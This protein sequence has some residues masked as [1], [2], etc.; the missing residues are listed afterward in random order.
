RRLARNLSDVLQCR[1]QTKV[2]DFTVKYLGV[3]SV[4]EPCG[5]DY[6]RMHICSGEI[7]RD[8]FDRFQ[9]RLE[10]QEHLGSIGPVAIPSLFVGQDVVQ[11]GTGS[12]RCA[13]RAPTLD[14]DRGTVE[15]DDVSELCDLVEEVEVLARKATGKAAN[16]RIGGRPKR[17]GAAQ[18]VERIGRASI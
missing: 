3:D 13:V 6:V 9:P 14:E 4:I 18:G 15:S 8:Q 17:K 7:A 2:H 16:H 12:K 1:S 11:R 5:G 10:V